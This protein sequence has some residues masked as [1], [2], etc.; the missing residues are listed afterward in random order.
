MLAAISTQPVFHHLHRPPKSMIIVTSNDSNPRATQW[1]TKL[2]G[3]EF[4]ILYKPSN[5]NRLADAL[6]RFQDN[7]AD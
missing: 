5:S 4:D 3:Y 7:S 1:L 2:L 6:S